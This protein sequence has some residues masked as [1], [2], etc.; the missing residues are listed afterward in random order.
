MDVK[1]S[2]GYDDIPCKFLKI[3]A[4][5]LAGILFQMVNIF[6]MNVISQVYL[7]L[8]KLLLYLKKLDRLFKENYKPV[9]I[10]TAI[11]KVLS[12]FLAISCLPSS[13]RFF[14]NFSLVFDKDIA[15]KPPYYWWLEIGNLN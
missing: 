11:S 13:A 9:S 10:L 14:Q 6:W 5:P 8:Q 12:E 4:T 7:N 2:V 3:G 1:K 15:A